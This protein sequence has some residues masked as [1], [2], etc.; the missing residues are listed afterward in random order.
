M[1]IRGLT[2]KEWKAAFICKITSLPTRYGVEE[3]KGLNRDKGS[4]VMDYRKLMDPRN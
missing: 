3:L 2:N 1:Q 4:T